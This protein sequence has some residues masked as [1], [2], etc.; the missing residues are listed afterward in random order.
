MY[1]SKQ[2]LADKAQGPAQEIPLVS[3]RLEAQQLS[4]SELL[5][6]PGPSVVITSP[7]VQ[8]LLLHVTAI[9]VGIHGCRSNSVDS[10]QRG[11]LAGEIHW[12]TRSSSPYSKK[13]SPTGWLIVQDHD[14]ETPIPVSEFR[15]GEE[16][17]GI[18]LLKRRI[19]RYGYR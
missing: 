12:S 13:T 2:W 18:K 1:I 9:Y 6:G 5:G 19:R 15:G 4:D 14:G 8:V 11:K 3:R 16:G 7:A 17:M 10:S